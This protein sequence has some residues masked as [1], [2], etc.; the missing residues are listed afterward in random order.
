MR[1]LVLAATLAPILAGCGLAR[2][3]YHNNLDAL[4]GMP[5]S[6][7]MVHFGPPITSFEA[8]SG[9][10]AYQ[11]HRQGSYQTNA[12][13]MRYGNYVTVN[14][15]QTVQTGCRVTLTATGP[16]GSD[17]PSKWIVAAWNYNGNNCY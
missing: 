9:R 8:G 16:A 14:P 6:E 5:I 13:A 1:Y 3:K 4:I 2:D 10:R 17:D 12:S 15:S 11:W 7:V